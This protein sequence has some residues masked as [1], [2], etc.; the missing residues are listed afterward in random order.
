MLPHL[1]PRYEDN[2]PRLPAPT[3]LGGHTATLLQD[4]SVLVTGGSSRRS[5]AAFP[6]AYL[7][8]NGGSISF[9][10]SLD[11]FAKNLQETQPTIFFAP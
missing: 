4:G 9:A 3:R 11:T 5:G 2:A 6:N 1:R 7:L 8:N 10:E